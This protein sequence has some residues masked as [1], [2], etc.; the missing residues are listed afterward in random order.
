LVNEQKLTASDGAANGVFG[1]SVAV[2]GLTFVAGAPVDKIGGDFAQD[3]AYVFEIQ[4][5]GWVGTRRLTASVGAPGEQFGR[6]AVRC[7]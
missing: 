4:G 5:R 2:S 1:S 3:S 6:V 7:L